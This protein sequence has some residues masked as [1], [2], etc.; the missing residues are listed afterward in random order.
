MPSIQTCLLLELC[1]AMELLKA[2]LLWSRILM[3]SPDDSIWIHWNFAKKIMCKRVTGT[4]W[5]CT[6]WTECG[7][8]NVSSVR[9]VCH[10]AWNVVRLPLVGISHLIVTMENPSGVGV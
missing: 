3:K 2:F 1:E 8:P 7:T 4:R 9:V 5:R 6:K 10:N